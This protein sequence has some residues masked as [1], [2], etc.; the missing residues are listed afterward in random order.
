MSRAGLRK[1]LLIA[2]FLT[3]TVPV[4][5]ENAILILRFGGDPGSPLP[6]GY[7][8]GKAEGVGETYVLRIPT[9]DEEIKKVFYD[10]EMTVRTADKTVEKIVAARAF[11]SLRE[12]NEA[13]EIIV[14]KLAESLPRE[15]APGDG[16]WQR[17]SA[18]GKVVGR[19]ACDQPRYFP[20]P[21][22]RL[23]I[24]PH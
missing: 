22:L 11:R 15:Y 5:A 21:V 19:T 10:T 14:E 7:D 6:Y 23:L 13:R 18:D 9:V 1:L 12:C 3:G 24:V 4:A 16:E 20:T 2:S 17:Q 8:Y